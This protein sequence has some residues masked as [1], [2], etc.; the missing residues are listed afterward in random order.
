MNAT[1]LLKYTEGGGRAQDTDEQD[2]AEKQQRF[3]LGELLNYTAVLNMKMERF[4]GRDKK[5]TKAL[6]PP[7]ARKQ[8]LARA[9]ER[10]WAVGL[11]LFNEAGDF[12][13]LP[14]LMAVDAYLFYASVTV[15][16]DKV[17]RAG[18][19]VRRCRWS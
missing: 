11:E 2:A 13:L 7:R 15:L 9:R 10:F 3:H 17:H 12:L 4:D 8:Q 5:A 16:G 19:V 6:L 14:K 18:L 1:A